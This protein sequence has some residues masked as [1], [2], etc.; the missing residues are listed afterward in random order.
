MIFQ[1]S[2]CRSC[3]CIIKNR[4]VSGCETCMPP[5]LDCTGGT[6]VSG[7][8]PKYEAILLQRQL[9]RYLPKIIQYA[10]YTK[11][12]N[13]LK[14]CIRPN[15]EDAREPTVFFYVSEGPFVDDSSRCKISDRARIESTDCFFLHMSRLRR[16]PPPNRGAHSPRRNDVADAARMRSFISSRAPHGSHRRWRQA[17][18][19]WWRIL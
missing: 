7:G 3:G 6:D 9:T 2:R 11:H 15:V 4:A 12:L 10:P 5:V 14:H 19:C 8:T 1:R 18:T 13:G 17:S 16:R